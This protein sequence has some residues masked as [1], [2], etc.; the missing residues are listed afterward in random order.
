MVVGTGID[1]V[2]VRR[3]LKAIQ[4]VSFLNK[5]Y[6]VAE[7]ELIEKRKSTAACNFA[8]KEA[9]AKAFGTGFA[10]FSPADIEILRKENG[11]PYVNLY[12]R[13][14]EISKEKGITGLHISLSDTK[15]IAVAYVVAENG[16]AVTINQPIKP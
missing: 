7:Q 6:T 5:C 4:K 3:V 9:V 15:D 16:Q 1:V 11:A 13:A 12:G 2:E 14:E 8:G 10:G